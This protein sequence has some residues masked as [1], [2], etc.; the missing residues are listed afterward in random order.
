MYLVTGCAF[1]LSKEVIK[2][3]IS[4]KYMGCMGQGIKRESGKTN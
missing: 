4:Q 3:T 1:E 2:G